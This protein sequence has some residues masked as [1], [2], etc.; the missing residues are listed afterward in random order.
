M[1]TVPLIIQSELLIHLYILQFVESSVNHNA[2]QYALNEEYVQRTDLLTKE[3]HN[4][5][6]ERN[7]QVLWLGNVMCI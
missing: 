2:Q 6:E 3:L 4:V 7:V 1:L 5:T